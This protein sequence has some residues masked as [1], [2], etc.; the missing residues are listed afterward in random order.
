MCSLTEYV[1]EC[2]LRRLL[3][4]H[5]IFV[6]HLECVSECVLRLLKTAQG[7]HQKHNICVTRGL[8]HW[9]IWQWQSDS[10]SLSLHSLRGK[11]LR[12]W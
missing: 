9:P 5:I 11:I 12:T 1:E 2:D 8:L 6:F 4:S 3:K 7:T 10:S